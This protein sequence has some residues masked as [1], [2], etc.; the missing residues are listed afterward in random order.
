MVFKIGVSASLFV[1][2]QKN[3]FWK[4]RKDYE[5]TPQKSST[6]GKPRKNSTI[7]CQKCTNFQLLRYLN[8]KIMTRNRVRSLFL[9][10]DLAWFLHKKKRKWGRSHYQ[11]L[12]S[13]SFWWACQMKARSKKLPFLLFC[14]AIKH[15]PLRGVDVNKRTVT[16]HLYS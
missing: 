12:K 10:Q 11:S 4:P 2:F 5:K 9:R 15:I 14:M 6:A 1:V 3:I 7:F 16:T 13:S 8:P